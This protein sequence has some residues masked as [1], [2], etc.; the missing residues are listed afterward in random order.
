[1]IPEVH[2]KMPLYKKKSFGIIIMI[3]LIAVGSVAGCFHSISEMYSDVTDIFEDGVDDDD[4]CIESYIEDRIDIAA[5]ICKIAR[6]NLDPS[7]DSKLITELSDTAGALK[8]ALDAENISD[9]KEKNDALSDSM[10]AVYSALR[11]TSDISSKDKLD[12][13]DMYA[14]FESLGDQIR[15]DPYN[16][17]ALEYNK[18]TSGALAALIKKITPAHDAVMFN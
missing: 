1:M 18:K 5:D 15:N 3:L 10:S 13:R 17:A 8:T 16:T 7:D 14:D 6:K 9:I 11:S 12:Y 2:N 4:E